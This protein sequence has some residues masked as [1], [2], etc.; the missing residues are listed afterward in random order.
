MTYYPDKWVVLEFKIDGETFQKVLGAWF[1]GYLDGDSWRLSSVIVEKIDHGN[2][3][4]F[5]NE[6]GSTY[7]CAKQTQGMSNFASSIYKRMKEL[8]DVEV[9]EMK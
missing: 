2:H 3:Y 7:M 6:S 9:V 4:E 5:L 8:H 1:G